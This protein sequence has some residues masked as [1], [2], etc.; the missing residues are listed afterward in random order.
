MSDV[1]D[2]DFDRLL[3][4]ADLVARL[5]DAEGLAQIARMRELYARHRGAAG[6]GS[7]APARVPRVFHQIW[8]GSPVPADLRA[9]SETWRALHPDWE[10]RLWTDREIADLDFG[11]RDLFEKATCWAQKSDLL[12]VELVHRFGGVYVDLDYQCFR[13]IDAF[14]QAYDFFGTSRNIL[15]AHLGWPAIWPTPFVVCNSLFGARPGHPLLAAY[16]ARVRAH[17]HEEARFRFTPGELP[18]VSVFMMGGPRR[19]DQIKEEGLRTYLPFHDIVMEHAGRSGEPEIVLPAVL[20]NPVVLKTAM[21]YA[22]PEFWQRCWQRGVWLPRL[23]AYGAI[24]PGAYANHIS[25]AR[26][27]S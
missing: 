23:G 17:W 21:L 27:L 11:T 10:L 7:G 13:P 9:L 1:L 5:A 22:M 8:M 18:R 3:D 20:F 4:P 19:L 26:W 14:A 15:I 16:L 2:A 6:G 25:K 24:P 12:R